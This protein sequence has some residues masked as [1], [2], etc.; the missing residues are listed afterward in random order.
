MSVPPDRH[1]ADPQIARALVHPLRLRLLRALEERAA[2]PSELAAELGES[3]GVVAYHVRTLQHLG[4]CRLVD[5]RPRRGAI[6]HFYRATERPVVTGAAWRELPTMVKQAA[7]QATLQGIGGAV[8]EAA[9]GGG[10]DRHD[11]HLSRSPVVLDEPGWQELST[12]M[13]VL[14]G[15]IERIAAESERRLKAADHAGEIRATAVL[16]L[17]E[18]GAPAGA[19]HRPAR[20]RRRSLAR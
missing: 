7:V 3:L 5:E 19:E 8:S 6:E 16:M 14:L 11:M 12:R 13:D 10:F 20:G 9:D 17:F 15:D 18:A 1:I 2:S 4:L